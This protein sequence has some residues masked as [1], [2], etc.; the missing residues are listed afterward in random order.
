MNTLGIEIEEAADLIQGSLS[1][2]EESISFYTLEDS[3]PAKIEG[4]Q[5]IGEMVR[6][7]W[8]SH[9]WGENHFQHNQYAD[10]IGIFR[11]DAEI[12][13]SFG[14]NDPVALLN[15]PL[16]T[17]KSLENSPISLK[18]KVEDQRL[19]EPVE[20]AGKQACTELSNIW[21]GFDPE[22][23]NYPMELDIA[24]Q[25]WRAVSNDSTAGRVKE[26]LTIW[27]KKA[28]PK[29]PSAAVERIVGVCNWDKTGGRPRIEQ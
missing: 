26:R 5:K 27:I 13:F 23:P 6:E 17:G 11:K 16:L 4:G 10:E 1:A 14:K 29:L 22:A 18:Q 2:A 19:I 25:A 8:N 3:L 7:F 9:W 24:L 15:S 12:Y 28:Y 21:E 20:V